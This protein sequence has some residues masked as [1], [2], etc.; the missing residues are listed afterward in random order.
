MGTHPNLT[1]ISLGALPAIV[2]IP[3]SVNPWRLVKELYLELV[4]SITN[5]TELE[6]LYNF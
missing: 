5:L 3:L 2:F 1:R 4:A 6:E